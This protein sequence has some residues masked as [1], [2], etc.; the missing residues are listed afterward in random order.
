MYVIVR[1]DSER[2]VVL[3]STVIATEPQDA[4]AM[5]RSYQLEFP[6]SARAQHPRIMR[7]VEFDLRNQLEGSLRIVEVPN[8]KV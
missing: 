7:L 1:D 8:A 2:K 3:C 6:H 4:A 5:L